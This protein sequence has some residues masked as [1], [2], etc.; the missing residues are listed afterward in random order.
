[1]GAGRNKASPEGI[2][3]GAAEAV[4]EEDDDDEEE[5]EEEALATEVF[6]SPESAA[7]KG[8]PVSVP[9]TGDDASCATAPLPGKVSRAALSDSLSNKAVMPS[10]SV[11]TP[12]RLAKGS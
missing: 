2:A 7:A 8:L 3:A 4:E 1:M 10:F 12:A 6:R 5:E 9:T 11:S